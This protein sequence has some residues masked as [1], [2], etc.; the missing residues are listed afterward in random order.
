MCMVYEEADI[1]ISLA[2][3]RTVS[4]RRDNEFVGWK[5]ALY[6]AQSN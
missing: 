5:A 2:R 3:H 4:D 6:N 1:Y